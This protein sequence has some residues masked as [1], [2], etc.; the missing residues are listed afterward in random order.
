MYDSKNA[1]KYWS[2]RIKTKNLQ[3]AVLFLSRPDYINDAYALWESRNIEKILGD[4]R[5]KKIVDIGCGGG[6]NLVPLAKKNADVIGVDISNEM[7]NYAEKF[8]RKNFC[9]K[10]IKLIQAN[11]WET[12]LPS[13]TSDFVLVVGI[14]EHVPNKYRKLILKEVKRILKPKG[15][16]CIVINN[17]KSIFLSQI[18]KWI[19]PTQ[20]SS[21]YFSELIDSKK[22]ISYLKKLGFKVKIESSNLNYSILFHLI[23]NLDNTSLSKLSK[24]S[25]SKLFGYYIEMDLNENQKKLLKN[26]SGIYDKFSNQ[27]FV[28]AQKI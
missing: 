5:K 27:F 9:L 6:R 24:T 12:G 2:E 13:N 25:I 11:G 26:D 28:T 20:K 19:K 16:S 10:N 23:S 18:P 7:L 21:G 3:R 4:V 14:L 8:A 17:K 15:K 22:I 1:A